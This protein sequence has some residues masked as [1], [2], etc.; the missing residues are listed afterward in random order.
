MHTFSVARARLLHFFS[1]WKMSKNFICINLKEFTHILFSVWRSNFSLRWTLK[2]TLCISCWCQ[3]ALTKCHFLTSWEWDCVG[4]TKCF[5]SGVHDNVELLS[6]RWAGTHYWI[7][8]ITLL[9]Y[10]FVFY[11]IYFSWR[12]FF[13]S[14]RTTVTTEQC[15]NHKALYSLYFCHGYSW[16]WFIQTIKP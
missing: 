12:F 6:I 3:R 16:F 8:S 7:F 4:F 11:S 13:N 5:I 2:E 10:C 15:I 9:F 14:Q 1:M